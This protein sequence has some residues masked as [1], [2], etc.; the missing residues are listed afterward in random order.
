MEAPWV[1]GPND[2]EVAAWIALGGE[3]TGRRAHAAAQAEEAAEKRK[4]APTI[5]GPWRLGSLQ[6]RWPLAVDLLRAE[7]GNFQK[8]TA[9]WRQ[10]P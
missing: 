1:V 3:C 5:G 2:P 8:A 6:G 9:Q 7:G 10:E 4:R